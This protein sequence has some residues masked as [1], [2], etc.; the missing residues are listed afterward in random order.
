MAPFIAL[1]RQPTARLAQN[2]NGIRTTALITQ[3]L[4]SVKTDPTADQK[5]EQPKF[6]R[7]PPSVVGALDAPTVDR[8]GWLDRKKQKL[9]DITNYDKAFAAHAAERRHLVEEATKS[10]FA[11]VHE[12]RKHG[13]KM[14]HASPKLIK[15]EKA[16]YMP[17][18]EGTNLERKPIHTTDILKDK[19]SLMSFVYAKYGEP[20]AN[21]FIE[22]FLKRFGDKKDIQLVEVNVQENFL[23]QLLLKAF[24]PTIR[25]NLAEERKANYVLLMK[26]ITRVRKMLDMTNQYIGY[27]FLVDENCKIRWVAHGNATSEEIGNMLGM[28][29]YLNE[30]RTKGVKAEDK[31]K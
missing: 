22:P 27:V 2:I 25:K 3:R 5:A 19:I 17:D 29:E 31:Q 12:M 21:S 26:D 13:G 30:K 23:K 24:V 6:F 11:D 1:F 9:R 8:N 4:L 7:Q 14:Y 28:T 15:A 18:F 10:Y 16:G 20:H